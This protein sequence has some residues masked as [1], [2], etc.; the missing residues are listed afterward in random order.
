MIFVL[1]ETNFLY[2]TAMIGSVPCGECPSEQASRMPGVP[3]ITNA[4][5]AEIVV[6]AERVSTKTASQ[7][8]GLWDRPSAAP[9]LHFQFQVVCLWLRLTALGR[10]L[11][12]TERPKW[13]GVHIPGRKPQVRFQIRR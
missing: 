2:L 6:L 1:G 10:E 8:Q 4:R 7:Q 12:Y 11:P 13:A 5:R 3:G 9:P